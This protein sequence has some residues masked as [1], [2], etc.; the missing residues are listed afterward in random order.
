MFEPHLNL[1][2]VLQFKYLRNNNNIQHKI[3]HIQIVDQVDKRNHC[4]LK[5]HF[6]VFDNITI[7]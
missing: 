1:N 4:F 6:P 2:E 5:Q 3:F 7:Q